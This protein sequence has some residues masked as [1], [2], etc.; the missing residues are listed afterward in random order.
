M[1][2]CSFKRKLI[3]TLI[4]LLV[5]NIFVAFTYYWE[6]NIPLLQDVYKPSGHF[7][8]FYSKHRKKKNVSLP[9]TSLTPFLDCSTK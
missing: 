6:C 2:W 5:I 1:F 4:I 7:W 8:V 3:V 9:F